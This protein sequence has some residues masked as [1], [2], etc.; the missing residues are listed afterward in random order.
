MIPE[1]RKSYVVF[2]CKNCGH[3]K[4]A[5]KQTKV[6]V[7]KKQTSKRSKEIAVSS[8]EEVKT[9]EEEKLLL[10]ELYKDSLEYFE[11]S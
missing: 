1:K 11:S 3:T 2:V 4:K 10:E 8:P 5:T 9:R 7:P 6:I